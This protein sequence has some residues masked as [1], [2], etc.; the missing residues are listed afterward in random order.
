MHRIA[1]AFLLLAAC[2][3]QQRTVMPA[4]PPGVAQICVVRPESLAESVTMTVN[5]NGRLV[6]ATRGR[7][8]VCWLAAPGTHQIGSDD[9]DT[10]PILLRAE[11]GSH[12]WLHQEVLELGGVAHAHLDF[13][14]EA[15]AQDLIETCEERVRVSVPGHEDHPSAQPVVPATRM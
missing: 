14:D 5:D 6:G 10:G 9:D 11:A 15:S 12:Y 7:T 8:Y 3:S 4:T 1:C 13:L 2:G